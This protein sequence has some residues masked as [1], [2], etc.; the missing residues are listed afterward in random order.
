MLPLTLLNA[1]AEHLAPGAA[2][3]YGR[4]E[5]NERE[6]IPAGLADQELSG[7]IRFVAS[8]IG[9]GREQYLENRMGA[10]TAEPIF[11]VVEIRFP[12]MHQTVPVA[13]CR[14]VDF[15]ADRVGFVQEIV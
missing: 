1:T 8:E 10:D 3:Y 15:L 5:V 2:T 13:A 6:G 7:R 12:A 14:G 11:A 9:C 4:A